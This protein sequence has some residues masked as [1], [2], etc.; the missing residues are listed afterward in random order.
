MVV[1]C[2]QHVHWDSNSSFTWHQPYSSKTAASTPLQWPFK[3]HCVKLWTLVQ[4]CMWLEC[5]EWFKTENSAVYKQLISKVWMKSLP[6]A[7][8]HT[9]WA[10]R[11]PPCSCHSQGEGHSACAGSGCTSLGDWCHG[12]N[13]AKEMLR[14]K[15][16]KPNNVHTHTHTHVHKCTHIHFSVF[17]SP[18][19][20]V[21]SALFPIPVSLIPLPIP[22][23]PP[24]QIKF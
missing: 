18:F 12:R 19:L 16:L 3:M 11:L 2:T 21:C 1:W 8:W 15:D 5:S 23:P 13:P 6:A 10:C 22:L 9:A 14:W 4:S 20:K 24:P 17:N 7:A